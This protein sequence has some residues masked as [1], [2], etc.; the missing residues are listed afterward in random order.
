[1]GKSLR[2]RRAL[3]PIVASIILIA[4]TITISVAA[5]AWMGALSFNF[6]RTE[7][8]KIISVEFPDENT[9]VVTVRNTGTSAVTITAVKVNGEDMTDET[10]TKV[11]SKSLPVTVDPAKDVVLTIT[12]DWK[13]GMK[14]GVELQT[15]SGNKFYYEAT[16][17]A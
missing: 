2:S 10:T 13:L 1:V 9:I 7:E 5:A 11:D 12:C 3:S 15:A 6:M 16:A 14:Y 8:L 4:V 17:P